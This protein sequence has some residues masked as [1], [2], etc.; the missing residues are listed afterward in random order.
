MQSPSPSHSHGC[1]LSMHGLLAGMVLHCTKG[2]SLESHGQPPSLSSGSHRP[3]TRHLPSGPTQ[4]L[5]NR[6]IGQGRHVVSS[7]LS[8]SSKQTHT[9]NLKS[10]QL[11]P[12]ISKAANSSG[13]SNPSPWRPGLTWCALAECCTSIACKGKGADKMRRL[14]HLCRVDRTREALRGHPKAAAKL[15]PLGGLVVLVAAGRV[16]VDLNVNARPAAGNN[17]RTSRSSSGGLRVGKRR[18]RRERDERDEHS[19]ATG[20]GVS[21]EVEKRRRVRQEVRVRK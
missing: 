4:L 14:V 5:R 21:R 10:L 6:S 20:H 11:L 17:R 7:S 12:A 9:P 1:S 13:S 2:D 18:A 15:A 8:P 3:P 16:A 19:G